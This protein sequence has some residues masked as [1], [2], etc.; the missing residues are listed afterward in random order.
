[1]RGLIGGRRDSV[2]VLVISIAKELV[3]LCAWYAAAKQTDAHLGIGKLSL[4]LF[5]SY[6]WSKDV[7]RVIYM[8]LEELSTLHSLS[9]IGVQSYVF[10]FKYLPPR[11]RASDSHRS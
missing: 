8:T 3:E 5:H 2:F 11:S 1:M 9:R 10:A 4:L 7:T 6:S